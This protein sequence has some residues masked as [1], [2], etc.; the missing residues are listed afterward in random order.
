V[1]PT[2]ARTER[3]ESGGIGGVLRRARADR[4]LTLADLQART[5]IPARYLAALEEERFGDLPPYPFARGFLHAAAEELGLDPRP[6][7]R[8]LAEVMPRQAPG[9]IGSWRRMDGA[10]VPAVRPS[11]VRRGVVMAAAAVVLT[12]GALAVY[13]VQQVRQFQR[14]PAP[15][16]GPTAAPLAP[17]GATPTATPAQTATPPSARV[18]QPDQ[19]PAVP[20]SARPVAVEVRAVGR[21]W[22]LV[23]AD[24]R[25]VFEGFVHTGDVRRWDA[26]TTIRIRVGNAG[27]VAVVIDGRELG[28]LGQPGE[29]VDRTYPRD[30]PP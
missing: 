26:Q 19:A 2:S 16:A 28:R 18:S 7:T 24:Q 11:R 1:T 21:S 15:L 12:G 27:A 14:E 25:T 13:F 10:I 5:R 20:R 22:L 6:L 29:V 4:G 9:T 3:P 30:A 17:G 23:V 8:R